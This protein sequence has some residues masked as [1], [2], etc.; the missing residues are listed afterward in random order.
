MS[1]T[2]ALSINLLKSIYENF[3]SDSSNSSITV[4]VQGKDPIVLTLD[5]FIENPN[6]SGLATFTNNDIS[7]IAK[8]YDLL[9]A[10]LYKFIDNIKGN[11]APNLKLPAGIP[12]FRIV[13]ALA[14]GTVFFDSFRRKDQNTY[15]NFLSKTIN[16]NHASRVYIRH[17]IDHGMAIESKWSSTTKAVET[18]YSQRIGF[19]EKYSIGAIAFAYS[20]SY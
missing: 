13:I 6:F 20:T 10:N 17:A 19:D 16:E 11:S 1:F 5:S 4:P 12:T 18:Y 7:E 15:Q 9:V 3:R 8:L 14:D 2:S